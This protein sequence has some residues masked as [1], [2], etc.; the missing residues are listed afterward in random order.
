M[1]FMRSSLTSSFRSSEKKKSGQLICETNSSLI[2][3]VG[4]IRVRIEA[5]L[6]VTDYNVQIVLHQ[7]ACRHDIY[8]GNETYN[9]LK[10]DLV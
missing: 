8:D 3:I 2:I 10:L 7:T 5:N 1:F 9:G 6:I 4:L